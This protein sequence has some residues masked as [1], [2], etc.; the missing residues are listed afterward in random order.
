MDIK[1][2]G[3][4]G[5]KE[6]EKRIRQL[7]GLPRRTLEL[8]ALEVGRASLS[9]VGDAVKHRFQ[10]GKGPFPVSQNKLGVR[11]RRLATSIRCSKPQL[12]ARTGEISVRFGSNVVYF[13]AHEFGFDGAVE[14]KAHSRRIGGR[15]AGKKALK[16]AAGKGMRIAEIRSHNRRMKI[17][18]RRLLGTHL[19]LSKTK[20]TFLN[21]LKKGLDAAIREALK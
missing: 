14:V 18:A 16:G 13:A 4:E 7:G 3:T 9:A 10:T 2:D 15:A 8:L 12:N 5:L 17:P 19:E 1:I 11:T 6:L 20:L 21:A